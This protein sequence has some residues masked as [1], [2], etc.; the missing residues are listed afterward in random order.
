[1]ASMFSAMTHAVEW[2]ELSSV[3]P[4]YFNLQNLPR[5]LANL[6]SD[7]WEEFSEIRQSLTQAVKKELRI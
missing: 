4:D 5:R 3:G 1:M 2:E 6:Q 7:P